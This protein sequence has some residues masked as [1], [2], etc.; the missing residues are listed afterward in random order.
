MNLLVENAAYVITLNQARQVL[1]DASIAVEGNIITAVDKAI[2][3]QKTYSRGF[4]DKVIDGRKRVVS[5]GFVDCHVHAHE[6]LSRCLDPANERTTEALLNWFYP[7]YASLTPEDEYVAS[8]LACI[9]MLRSG[10]T[11]FIDLGVFH[12]DQLVRATSET[13]IRAVVGRRVMD[14]LPPTIPPH[15]KPW[16]KDILYFPSAE[17]AIRETKE[18]LSRWK[19]TEGDRIKAWVTL[20]GKRTI[21]DELYVKAAEL[22]HQEKVGFYFHMA[23]SFEEAKATEQESGDWPMTHLEKLGVLDANV[24]IA[25]GVAVKNEEVDLLRKRGTKICYC[26][27]TAVKEAK[28]ATAIGRFPEML[29]AG[30]TVSLG[31]DGVNASG[32]LNMIR[33][34]YLAASL[35]RDARMDPM[36]ITPE[37]ALEMGTRNGA[38]S[39]LGDREIGSI[40]PGKKADFI[41]FDTTRPEWLP[42]LDPVRNLVYSAS[43]QSVDTVVVDGKVVVEARTVTTLN[44]KEFLSRAQERAELVLQRAG[45]QPVHGW[46][47]T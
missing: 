26:P 5:P 24:L 30:V 46:P 29:K 22:A 17:A 37:E 19:H 28:G 8:T 39:L 35:H 10:T 14:R 32:S 33:Q 11:C 9:D 42:I 45:L 2:E 15:W 40:E 18:I 43:S 38:V 3:V 23:S 27:G 20:N 21:T 12:V 4:F 6:H 34:T 25:H 16:M 36:V 1:R 41:L 13:G 47:I 31:C 7:Y 44:E